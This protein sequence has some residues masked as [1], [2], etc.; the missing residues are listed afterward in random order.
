MSCHTSL[1]CNLGAPRWF[2]P[3]KAEEVA[4]TVPDS[5]RA[6]FEM[7]HSFTKDEGDFSQVRKTIQEGDV[8]AF[9]MTAKEKRDGIFHGNV[10]AVSYIIMK[11]AHLAIAV[12]DPQHPDR[13]LL[14]TSQGARGPNTIDTI[15]DLEQH[16]IDVYRLDRWKQFDIVRLREFVAVSLKKANKVFAYNFVGMVGIYSNCMEPHNQKE[17]GNDYLC[18]TAVAAALH[19]AGLNLDAVRCCEALNMVS[20]LRV[21]TSSG[22]MMSASEMTADHSGV[23]CRSF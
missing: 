7:I 10:K 12:K 16:S 22:R 11:Y 6:K 18:S 3:T 4:Y 2:K 23:S 14:Y 21:V 20:P 9:R 13:L 8:V 17:I 1:R 15:A 19:Y 5:E